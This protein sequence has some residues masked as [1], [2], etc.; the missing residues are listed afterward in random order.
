MILLRLPVPGGKR[1]TLMVA[2]SSAKRC[3]PGISTPPPPE[4]HLPGDDPLDHGLLEATLR[5][6]LRPVNQNVASDALRRSGCHVV[7]GSRTRV[8]TPSSIGSVGRPVGV[9]RGMAVAPA[10]AP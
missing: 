5:R 2:V 1:Q 3:N 6:A 7:A 10:A 8:N 4:D 9:S